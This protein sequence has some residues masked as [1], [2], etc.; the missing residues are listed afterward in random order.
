MFL[1]FLKYDNAGGIQGQLRSSA[2]SHP[3]W[4]VAARV[5]SLVNVPLVYIPRALLPSR[6]VGLDLSVVLHRIIAVSTAAVVV[7]VVQ[8]TKA[9][10]NGERDEHTNVLP[11]AP[12][13]WQP[14]EEEGGSDWLTG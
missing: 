7:M 8:V 4:P 14:D 10:K 6:S 2:A 12:K 9:G 1:F 13:H 3:S 11:D 5:P